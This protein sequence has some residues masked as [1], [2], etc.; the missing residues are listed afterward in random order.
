MKR[1]DRQT[2]WMHFLTEDDDLLETYNIIWD[3]VSTDTKK[4][5]QG[6]PVYNKNF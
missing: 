4:E 5:F 2:K 3:Q 1:N 6:E